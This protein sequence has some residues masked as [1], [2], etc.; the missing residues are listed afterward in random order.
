ML[1]VRGDRLDHEFL[2]TEIDAN[3]LGTVWEQIHR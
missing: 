1:Q 3:D 2:H